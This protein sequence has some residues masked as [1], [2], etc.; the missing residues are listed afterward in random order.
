MATPMAASS[1][2]AHLMSDGLGLHSNAATPRQRGHAAGRPRAPP[3]ESLGAP[4]DDEGEGFADDQ[5]PVR[6]RPTDATNIPRV[7]DK[8]GLLIQDNFETF[9]EG[10]APCARSL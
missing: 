7:E 1:D 8:I 5:V 6:T 9:I 3:S 10:Y 4:S 2:G